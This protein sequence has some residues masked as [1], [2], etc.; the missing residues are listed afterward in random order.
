[1]QLIVLIAVIL[2]AAI[3][4]ALFEGARRRH[5]RAAARTVLSSRVGVALAE[6]LENAD[7]ID[8]AL[9][10]LVPAS[11]DWCVLHVVEGGHLVRAA[12]VHRDP[13]IERHFRETVDRRPPIAEETAGPAKVVQGGRSYLIREFR[14]GQLERQPDVEMVREAGLGSC[15]SVPL[16]ARRRGA[17]VLTLARRAP[18][19][20][21]EDDLSW[22]EDLALRIGLHIEHRRLVLEAKALFNQTVSANFVSTPDGRIT[23]CNQTFA[24]LVGFETIDQVLAAP[25]V[26]LC[27]SASERDRLLAEIR[28][29]RRIAGFESVCRQHGGGSV[30]VTLAAAGTF[31]EAGQLQTFAGCLVDR[32]AQKNLEEQLRAAQRLEAVGQLAGGIAH[33]FNNLLTVIMGCIDLLR[34]DFPPGAVDDEDTLEELAKAAGRAAALTQQLLAFSRRQ[35]LQ[36]R[37]VDLNDALRSA[38]PM[39]RLLL[40]DTV[41]MVLDLDPQIE[42]VKVDPNQLDQVLVNLIVNSCDAMPGGGTLTVATSR[43]VVGGGDAVEYRD[44]APGAY[45]GLSVRDTGLGMDETTRQRVFEPF[46]T[47]KPVGKGT[48][49]GLST[50]YGIVKQSGG[51]VSLTSA[52]GHGTTVQVCL[53][54]AESR[55]GVSS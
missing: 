11:A 4:F 19:A 35:V 41:V 9:R 27:E 29:Q 30:A 28:V 13:A 51:Y 16:S 24:T 50:V 26:E 52:P 2:A 32:S 10:L 17:G 21:D 48:G 55:V 42:P 6:G 5:L 45:V 34:M 15:I 23:A 43:V 36:P 49:L 22:A 37:V 20:Y 1:M 44:V 8:N 14:P 39:L 3:A 53:P 7:T 40:R 33:D 46:F 47:T 54:P 18:R 31:D 25:A 38:Q 12:L